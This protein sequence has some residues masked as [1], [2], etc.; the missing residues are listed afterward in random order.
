MVF[1]KL[2][3]AGLPSAGGFDGK[4]YPQELIENSDFRKFDEAL[5]MVLDL[6]NDITVVGTALTGE[7]GLEMALETHP[8]VALVDFDSRVF[9]RVLSIVSGIPS[10]RSTYS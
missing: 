10:F 5:R 6:E 1:L 7:E 3:L 9:C 2:T 8:D 4:A